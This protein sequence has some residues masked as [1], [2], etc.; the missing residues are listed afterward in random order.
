MKKFL[1]NVLPLVA[2]LVLPWVAK[3]QCTDGTPCQFTI[4]G[5]DSYGDGWEGSL[6]IYRN[7][8]QMSTFTVDAST[9]TQTFTVCQGDLVRIDW[10][11]SDQYYENTFTITGGDGTVYIS[12]GAGHN[13][14]PSGTVV[15][16]AACPTCITPT[17]LVASDITSDGMTISWTDTANSGASYSIDYWPNGG[18]TSTVT[19]TG[20]SYTFTGLDANTG[21][22]FAVKAVCSASDESTPL[23]GF[24]GTACG[25][26][27]CDMTLELGSS[28]SYTNPFTYYGGPASVELFQNGVS[29]GAYSSNSSVEVC[30]VDTVIVIYHH[31]GYSWGDYYDN[32]AS[33][34]IRDGGGTSMYSGGMGDTLCVVANP[35]PSCIPPTALAVD[36]ANQTSITLTWTPRS[37]AT[38]FAVYQGNILVSDNVS[39][40]FYTFTNLSANSAY[41]LGVQAICSSTDSSNIATLI[42]RT[43]C[44][45]MEVPFFDNFDSYDNGFF[46]PCWHRLKK[47]GTDPSVNSQYHASGSQ[48]MYLLSY[49]DT[50]LFVTPTAVPLVGNQIQVSYK[51]YMAQGDNN[52]WLKAGV[53]TDTS[54]MSTFIALDSI[55]YHN[56]NYAFEE[57]D[58]NTSTLDPTAT[59]WVAWMFWGNYNYWDYYYSTGAIDDV[60]ITELS[61]CVR[62]ATASVGT[63]GAHQVALSWS[64]VD[65][66]S[67]YTVYYGTVNDPTSSS[68]Q[69][70]PASDTVFTLT[71]LLP[72]THYFAWVATN[73]GGNESDLRYAGSF[74]TLISCPAVNGLTVD[75]T[76]SDGATISWHPGDVETQWLVALDSD[77]FELVTDSVYIVD[78]LDPMT[79]HTVYVRAYCDEEDTSTVQSISFAT[80]CADATCEVTVNMEDS[81]GDGWNGNAISVYQAGVEVGSV[82]LASGY[83]AVGTISVCSTAPMEVRFVK[84]SYSNEMGGSVI[85]AGGD[86][87]FTITGMGNYSTG[88]VLATSN[89]PCPGCIMPSDVMA[90][91]IDSNEVTFTWTVLPDVDGYIVSFNGDS[92]ESNSTGSYTAYNL[93]P[94]TTYTFSVRAVCQTN[95]DTSNARTIVVRTACGPMNIP[96]TEGFENDPAGDA[97]SCWNVVSGSP[98]N[99]AYGAHSGSQCLEFGGS[100]VIATGVVPLPGDSIYVSFWADHN[101]GTLEAGVMTNPLFDSTFI[102]LY[103]GYSTNDYE[104]IEFNTSTLSH[105]SSYYVAFRY[106]AGFY[107]LN[108]DDVNIRLYEGCMYP[109]NVTATPAVDGATLTWVN[110]GSVGSFAVEYR[111]G[112]GAWVYATTVSATTYDLTG[113]NAATAYEVRVGTICGS[114]TLWT[115]SSFVT[116]CSLLP[117]P[118]FENFYSADGTL[119]PCWDYQ[120]PVGWNNWPL[121]YGNG[122][123]IFGGYSAG[124]P[125]VLP[126]FDASFSK[127]QITFYTKCRP[128]SE[129]DGILIGVADAAGNLIEWIDTLYHPNHSQAAWVE[130][131]YNFLDYSGP[132][133]RI[134]LGRKLNAASNLWAS[135]DS[136]TVISLPS[137]YP[138]DSLTIYNAIDPDHTHFTW[139]SL[140]QESEWQVYVDT[141]TV[142]IENVPDSLLTNVYS[143]YYEIPVG[144]LQG[145]GIYNFYVRANCGIEQSNWSHYT[146]GAGTYVMNNS[147]VADTIVA[148]GLVVYDNGGPVAGY[149]DNSNSAVVILSE[150]VGS[151]L[152]IFGGQFGW[153][154]SAIT[155]TVYDG[156]GTSGTVLYQVNNTGT[157][158]YTLDSVLATSTT[159]AMTI[160]FVCS[161]NYVHTGYEL[162][163]HCVGAALCERPSQLQGVMTSANEAA[164]SWMGSSASYDLYYKPIDATTWT[165]QSGI[166]TT[167]A[168]LT[169]LLP[170]TTYEIQVVGICG[171]D[172]STP[173]FPLFLNTSY[174]QP[175]CDPVTNVAVGNITAN[176]A[177]V[178][179]TAPAG[180][181]QWEVSCAGASVTVNTNPYTLANLTPH[182]QYTVK[183]RALC[184]GGIMSEWSDE[185]SFETQSEQGIGEVESG[186]VHLY[187]N[188]ATST[189]TLDLKGIEGT[190]EVS[191]IDLNGRKVLGTQAAQSLTLDLSGVAKGTYFV[192][193]TGS[194]ITTVQKLVVR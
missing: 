191:L 127:L 152:Q 66:A 175:V 151:E 79:G 4:V 139:H 86:T 155:L 119:P 55:G 20:T 34:T 171:S 54:D 11:G 189:V 48:S 178:S 36:T 120:S 57:H 84:G 128:D 96:Y 111:T 90:T 40:T 13:Y 31:S 187:P 158:N 154:E 60:S 126:E 102:P 182:T 38:Q 115:L 180:Q 46:P 47:H 28:D 69:S 73:C 184:D 166:A 114:D 42:A 186:Y 172:T 141:V 62:P 49:L 78:G 147:A 39:D 80:A 170:D 72:E 27:T 122:E 167:S 19:A 161:G 181:S 70:A 168:V 23:H 137:C 162:Y 50:N 63:V 124:I 117:V 91:N 112:N 22:H 132:G 133:A 113:L 88:A 109:N 108:I 104:L 18:D 29:Y 192:R 177:V 149:Y 45:D 82:T 58:F 81:Y 25:G 43:E 194:N 136:I 156:V 15:E 65:G 8:V 5:E 105:D 130:H 107:T 77:D 188:P 41:T 95:I 193:V 131:T 35:C 21:Y 98:A 44:G 116:N 153:G 83:D 142:D 16:F 26:S 1:R 24:F 3:A 85:G 76:T 97:P 118:Y 99:Y 185:V 183:V 93:D 53:M 159:G 134:A 101:G 121:N 143:R 37:G 10:S 33:I 165:I 6:T 176:S 148:C 160:T 157:T 135:I 92:Y 89:V 17:N 106:T 7:N 163:I 32:Y 146:F 150:N 71:G 100:G 190:A 67:D 30:S 123:L 144:V 9:N 145:G 174:E 140:G 2:L 110:N 164:I 169:S 52:T 129:G 68:L 64:A 59:Y 94:N 51:V 138:V 56:F 12:N 103:T 61:D 87:L 14:A 173:S 74:T 179:W 125:A 75:T